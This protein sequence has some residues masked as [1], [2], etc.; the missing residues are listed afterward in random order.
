LLLVLLV[1]T[2]LLLLLLFW[3]VNLIIHV[4]AHFVEVLLLT[5]H[6]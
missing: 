5:M 1:V 2:V 4:L 6:E 3:R